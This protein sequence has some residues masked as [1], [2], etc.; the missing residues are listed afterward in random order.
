MFVDICFSNENEK[1][2]VE[3]ANKLKIPCLIFFNNKKVKS[4]YGSLEKI[5]KIELS[6]D[7]KVTKAKTIYYYD[8]GKKN[9]HAPLKS[10]NHVN[11]KE[12]KQN[13]SIV[14]LP[15]S[16]LFQRKKVFEQLKFIVRLCQKYNVSMCVTSFAHSPY[17]LKSK[18]DLMSFAK[19]LGIKNVK[20]SF[21]SL[22][23]FLSY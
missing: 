4:Y 9:F 17:E 11:I 19:M 1:E 21:Y 18:S 14:A 8:Y 20:K 10:I 2:F 3:I 22:Y 16:S 7:F 15:F 13:K 23:D 6:S 12:I 5:K